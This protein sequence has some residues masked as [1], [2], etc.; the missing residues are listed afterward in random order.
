M[1]GSSKTIDL[2]AAYAGDIQH[3]AKEGQLQRAA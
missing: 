1:I 2:S 3:A